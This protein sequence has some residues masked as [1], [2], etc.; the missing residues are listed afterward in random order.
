MKIQM[1]TGIGVH[2]CHMLPSTYTLFGLMVGFSIASDSS[3]TVFLGL[4]LPRLGA[5]GI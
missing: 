3:Y 2:H 5:S 4:P 1:D